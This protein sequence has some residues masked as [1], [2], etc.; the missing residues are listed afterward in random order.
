MSPRQV[1]LATAAALCLVALA[2]PADASQEV[3]A[4][5]RPPVGWLLDLNFLTASRAG[6]SAECDEL[7]A[8]ARQVGAT[9]TCHSTSHLPAWGLDGTVTL[10]RYAGVK[11]GYLDLGQVSLRANA[12]ART[13]S[14]PFVIGSSFARDQA[15][16]RARGVSIV[17]LVRVP[18]GR[19]VPFGELG[20]W[21]WSALSTLHLQMANT[22][23]NVETHSAAYD[24]R[25]REHNWDPIVGGG[26]ELWLT[27]RFALDAG[28]RFIQA[29]TAN[30][31]VNERFTSLAVGVK[32]GSR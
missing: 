32:V 8:S 20:A 12:E 27:D 13:V 11:V 16:G 9:I 10:F 21:R 23:N 5:D 22:V 4:G 19:V 25:T 14:G 7:Y 15:F 2:G 30:G 18:I 28:L 24:E 3:P 17:G 6:G 31:L 1:R 29:R 26:V